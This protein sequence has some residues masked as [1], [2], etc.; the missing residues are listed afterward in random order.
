[1]NC[2]RLSPNSPLSKSV[3]LGAADTLKLQLTTVDGKKAT[4]PHQAFLTLT[5]PAT[6]VEES[7]IFNVK[8]SGKG[9]VNLVRTLNQRSWTKLTCIGPQGPP[10]SVPHFLSADPCVHR[11]WIFRVLY[12]LQGQSLR[13]ECRPR[14]Q[15]SA[16]HSREAP[17]LRCREG[18][19]PHIPRRPSISA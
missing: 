18:D 16:R 3:S 9:S 15:R 17:P 12:T 6:G 19:S 13:P 2:R 14:P 1:M 8:D 10:A 11:H 7:F 4:R 5:D